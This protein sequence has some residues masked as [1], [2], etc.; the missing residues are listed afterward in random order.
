[1]RF[2]EDVIEVASTIPAPRGTGVRGDSR[3]DPIVITVVV[4]PR[5]IPN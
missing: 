4:T 5:A 2:N 1:M 3:D